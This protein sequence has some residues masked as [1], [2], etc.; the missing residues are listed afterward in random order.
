MNVSKSDQL[1]L[2]SLNNQEKLHVESF[3]YQTVFLSSVKPDPT[4][5]RF[6]PC[7][8][9]DDG[10]A[11]LFTNRKLSKKELVNIYEAEGHVLIGKSCLINCLKHGSSDWTKANHTI[12]SIM[13]LGNNI[14]VSEIIQVPTIYPLENGQY[15]ILTG[16]RRFFA[17]VYSKGYGSNSQFKIYESKPLLTKV[18]QF[19]ENASREDLPQYG[20]LLAFLSAL[21]EIDMVNTAR[22][23]TGQKKLTIKET[24]ANLGISMGAFDNYNVL[25]R[26]P[27]VVDAYESGLSA[28]FVKAKKVVLT[29][30]AEYKAKHNKTVLNVTDKREISEEIESRLLGKK[31]QKTGG[32]KLRFKPIASP[33]TVKTLLTSNITELATG[34][35]WQ[36]VDW[37]DH[38]AV[39]NVMATV[40]E[41]LESSEG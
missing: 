1:I 2:S 27:C 39:T 13:E 15:Q 25:T 5:A 41:F 11:E 20:K 35:D 24:A 3:D 37:H 36:N 21:T 33:A 4:N 38:K 29:A 28:S 8:F 32:K 34:I 7:I 9:I 30:E 17:L 14:S 19:Q 16:H 10:H 22:L 40:I 23:K 18:K 26:Y 12:E 6:F 31:S